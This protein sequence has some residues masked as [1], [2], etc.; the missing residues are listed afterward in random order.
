[1]CD[2]II[3]SYHLYYSVIDCGDPPTAEDTEMM[4]EQSLFMDNVTF[5][6]KYGYRH[7]SGQLQRYCMYD[8]TWNGTSPTCTG[9]YFC[10]R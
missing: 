10:N 4:L 8:G 7:T 9:E 3:I 5:E 2:Y 6:C 1:M